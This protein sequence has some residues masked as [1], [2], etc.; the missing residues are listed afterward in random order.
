MAETRTTI[1]P[2]FAFGLFVMGAGI[3]L[4]L[5]TLNVVDAGRAFAFWPVGL[6]ALGATILARDDTPGRF[7]GFVWV[8]VGS[9]W[10]LRNV[11]WITVGFWQVFWPLLFTA[12]GFSIVMRTLREG[13]H[14][15]RVSSSTSHLFA[16]FSETKR[17][18]DGQPFEGATMTAVF[19]SCDLDLRRA[20]IPPGEERVI[21]LFGVFCGHKILV[22]SEWNVLLN[23]APVMSEAKDDRVAPL[24]PPPLTGAPPRVIV[25]GFA[26]LSEVKVMA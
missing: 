10:L 5:D 4:M 3:V 20:T 14:L 7:W 21:E 9:W 23:V 8:I 15:R 24:A 25:R 1:T 19:G 6:I 26:L 17:K 12:I 13:G 11:G 18:L 22:P 16:V 2:Q